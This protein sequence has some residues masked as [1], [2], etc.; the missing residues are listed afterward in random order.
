MDFRIR[1]I[2]ACMIGGFPHRYEDSCFHL[3]TERVRQETGHNLIPYVD[4]YSALDR[5]PRREMLLSDGT[6]LTLK[7]QAIVGECLAAALAEIIRAKNMQTGRS[8]MPGATELIPECT[9]QTIS[10]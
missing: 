6:H 8:P 1:A 9:G 10:D 7:G 2:G 3:A 4:V 5:H